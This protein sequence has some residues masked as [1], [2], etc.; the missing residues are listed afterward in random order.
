MSGMRPVMLIDGLNVY[1]RHFIANPS[2]SDLGHHVG[3]VVGFMKGLQL[4]ADR[5]KPQAIYVVWEGGGSP[6]RRA[7][8]SGYKQGRKPQKLNRFY[9]SDIPDTIENRNYQLVLTIELLKNT[10][11]NQIYVGDCEA[12]DI[13]GFLVK[14][15]FKDKDIVIVSSDKDYYQLLTDKV[16]QWSPGQKKFIMQNDVHKKFHI[17]VHNF[18]TV[19]CFVGDA[20]DGLGGIKGAGFK[21]MA[22][23]FPELVSDKH[24][25]VNDIIESSIEK[26]SSSKLKL[27]SRITQ[28]PEVPLR[29]WKLMYLDTKNLSATHIQKI[30][31]E[32][33][34]FEPSR[35]K[36]NL[37]KILMRE[38]I[39]TFD[40]DSFFLAINSAIQ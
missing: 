2:M 32:I 21:T 12:D 28:D 35:N 3:G 39:R 25:S 18:C 31:G 7:I 14:N 23:R 17:P 11:I 24:I 19:R 1:T 16:T 8:Y 6:R 29:N 20:S 30:N 22:S 33:D 40:A 4:L 38:G 10:P 15:R 36:I 34:T 5:I 26:S 27:Y 37:M 9:G 13:I